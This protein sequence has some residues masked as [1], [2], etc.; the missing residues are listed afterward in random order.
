MYY[1]QSSLQIT[2]G[3]KFSLSEQ[4]ID[5]MISYTKLISKNGLKND[6]VGFKF[7]FENDVLTLVDLNGTK[8][9]EYDNDTI[10]NFNLNNVNKNFYVIDNTIHLVIA[11]TQN[12]KE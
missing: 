2:N 8:I 7:C 9:N 11:V 3:V 12:K 10:A 6:F 4:M 1:F 5:D